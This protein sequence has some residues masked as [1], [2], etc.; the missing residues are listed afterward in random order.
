MRVVNVDKDMVFYYLKDNENVYAFDTE[1]DDV[2]NLT[3]ET[4]YEIHEIL[5][6]DK[7]VFFMIREDD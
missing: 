5:N 1:N 3:D 7:Y 6:N 2:K 4:V